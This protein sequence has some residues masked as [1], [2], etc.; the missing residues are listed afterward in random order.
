MFLL[1]IVALL[2]QQFLIFK[3]SVSPWIAINQKKFTLSLLEKEIKLRELG[4]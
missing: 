3:D 2:S 1:V 4:T